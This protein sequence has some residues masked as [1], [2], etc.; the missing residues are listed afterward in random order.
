L[1]LDIFLDEVIFLFNTSL[2]VTSLIF[3]G[4]GAGGFRGSSRFKSSVF[5]G[6]LLFDCGAGAAG[7]LEDL[8]LL[9]RLEA[10]FITHLH[11]DHLSGL[12]D[13][14]VAMV[15]AKRNR[16]LKIYSPPGLSALLNAYAAL[17]NKLSDEPNNFEL[18]IYES[19][20]IRAEVNGKR[21]ESLKLD[22]VVTNLGFLVETPSFRLFYTG[23]TREPSDAQSL[24]VDYLIH[25]A[26][27]SGKQRELAK[28]YGHSTST[29]A[30]ETAIILKAKKLFITHVDNHL[31]TP[32][33]K[34]VEAQQVFQD[35]VLPDDLEA[36]NI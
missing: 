26:T 6:D 1:S 22:H 8:G 19:Q 5:L 7:R 11:S 29:E 21:V 35:T 24:K 4:T 25:E 23:D 17:G 18:K 32:S 3:L 33:E 12:Y 14:L 20:D 27:F 13:T 36:F 9:E 30:A 16:P 31:D 2:N 34:E 28:K 10:I 15:V